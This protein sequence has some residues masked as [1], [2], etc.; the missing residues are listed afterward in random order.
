[1]PG[2]DMPGSLLA[3]SIQSCVMMEVKATPDKLS[4]VITTESFR[5]MLLLL[6]RWLS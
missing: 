5:V 6:I 4:S 1:M 3:A 2:H